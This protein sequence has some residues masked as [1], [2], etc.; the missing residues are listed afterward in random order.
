MGMVS[1]GHL[2]HRASGNRRRGNLVGE[3]ETIAG[4]AASVQK[5]LYLTGPK[6]MDV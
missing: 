3:I 4:A 5:N 6:L 1:T 2:V